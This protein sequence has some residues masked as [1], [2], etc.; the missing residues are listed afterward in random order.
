VVRMGWVAGGLCVGLLGSLPLQAAAAELAIVQAGPQGEVASLEEANEVRVVFSEP[1]VALGRIPQPV[2]APFLRIAPSLAGSFRWSGTNT[3]IFTPADHARLPYATRYEVTVD[4]TATS[5][6]GRQLPRLYAFSFTTPT[7]RL[8][9]A[10]W[11]RAG[12]RYDAPAVIVLRFNQPVTHAATSPHIH[13]QYAPHEWT[14]PELPDEARQ[15]LSTVDPGA[16]HDFEAKVEGARAAAGS[17]ETV[18]VGL[19]TSWDEKAFPPSKDMLVFTTAGVPPPEAWIRAAIGPAIKGVQGP[20]TPGKPQEAT[21]K[22]ERTLFIDGFRC[23]VACDPDDHNPIVLRARATVKAAR[24]AVRVTD[25]TDPAAEAVLKAGAL[26]RKVEEEEPAESEEDY[27]LSGEV[28]LQDLGYAIRPARTY[29]ARVERTLKSVDGQVLGYTW[30]GLVENWHQRAFTSFGSGHGVWESGGGPLLPFQARNLESVRQWLAP[31]KADVLMPQ[32]RALQAESFKLSPPGEGTLR[33]LAPAPDAL[34]SYG[35]DLKPFL[36]ERG[37]GLVWAA[38]QDQDRMPKAK[39]SESPALKST[40]VQVTNLGISVK[41]SP[42]NVLVFVT[43]LDDGMPVEGATVSIRTLENT[44]YWTGVTDAR[45]T[46]VAPGSDLRDAE[47]HWELRFIVVA[48]KDGDVAYVASDWNEGVEPWE[49]SLTYDL[50]EARPLLRGAVF[51]DRG[52]YKLGEEVH[53]KTLLRSDTARGIVLLP[54]ATAVEVALQDSQG[55]EIDK[56]QVTLGEWSSADWTLRIPENGPLGRYG[57]TATVAGHREPVRGGFL[58]AAYRR[59]DFRVDANL[60]GETSLAGV[61]LKGEVT[62]RYLFGASMAS[63]PVRWTYSKAPL[64]DVPTAVTDRF[65]GERYAFLNEDWDPGRRRDTETMQT[66]EAELD[67]QGQLVLD[68]DTDLRSGLPYR[69]TLEGEVT[70]A[71]RQTIAGRASFRVDP[72]PWYI[73]LRRPPYFAD[74]KAG[75]DTEV[76]TADVSGQPVAGVPVHV[77]LMQVQWHSVRRAEGQGF[78]TWE[79]E[80]KEVEAGAWDVTTGPAPAPLH[81]P[82]ESGGSFILKATASD[83]EGRSTTTTTS[84]YV[85]GPGYT[86]W[87]RYDHN[88][89][90]LVP[91]KKAYRPGDVARILV[92]SPWE[93]ATAL[94]TTEREGVRTYKTFA[95]SSTQETVSVLVTEEDIPNVYV[96]VLLVKG[97]TGSYSAADT[98]DPG[99]PAFRLG[100]VELRVEEASRRLDVKLSTDREEYRPAAKAHVDV[101]IKD[102]AGRGGPAEVTLWA[103]DYGVLSLTAYK[104][105]DVLGSVYVAKALQV[106]NEDSRQNIISRRVLVPKGADEG[107]GGG[108]EEGPGTPVRKDFRVLAFWL[109]SLVTDARGKASADV[110]LPESLT[111]YRIMA[112]AGD[113]SSRFGWG[114]R[115]IRTSKPVLLKAAFPRFLALGDAARFGSVVHSQLKEK[116]TA[117]VTMKSLDPEVLEVTGEPRRTA[118]VAAKGAAELRFD[119]KARAVGRARVRMTVKLL[120]ESDAFEEVLPVEVLA[121]PEVVAAYGVANPEAHEAVDLPAGVVPGFGGLHVETAST[122]LVGLGE[123]ARYLVDYPYGCAEQ[124]ASAALALLL[125]ADLGEAFRLPGIEPAHLKETVGATLE[126]LEAYQC[127][128]GGFAFWKGGC[129]SASPYLTSYV[130]HVYQRGQKAGYRV[131][132]PVLDRGYAYLEKALAEGAP[133]DDG[134]WPAYTA[135]QAFA[136]KVLSEAGRNEDSHLTRL[137]D[138]LDRMPVFALSHLL[139]A[140]SARGEKGSRPDELRRRIHN[141]IL[142]EGGSAHV[143]ELSDPYLLWFWSSN[144]RSTAMVLGSLVRDPADDPLVP[145]I[146]RWLMKVRKD[147]RWGNT[148]ENAHAM[149]ALVD[150]YKRYE[151]EVPDFTGTVTLG[152]DVLARPEFRGRSTAV[153]TKDLPMRDLLARG[154]AGERLDLGFRKEG[155]GALHYVARLK[156][157]SNEPVAQGADQGF[158]IERTYVPAK[159]PEGAAP[160]Q[161]YQTGDLVTVTLKLRL[162]KERRYVAVTDPLPA[163]FEA[164]ES[165]FATTASDLAREQDAEESQDDDWRAWWQRGGFDHVERHDDRVLLF[166]TRLAEG[167]H[168][169]SYAV[170]ATTAGVFRTAPAHAEE[171]YEPEVFGRTATDVIEVRP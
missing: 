132:A 66:K 40:L 62:G 129:H 156:Y 21:I 76:V 119:V 26:P 45:G 141:A 55:Q 145:G 72:A 150:Y 56:R 96:S 163:G 11:Y 127:P 109:G 170:R 148:Q 171:M 169:F 6:A 68:L 136:V 130:L 47:R 5:L 135:W 111:T 155:A 20:E 30:V 80:R 74:I 51:S 43:R 112:V 9:Q 37:T 89:I 133:K 15:R 124:R 44:V 146:V 36:S 92:K 79:T 149:E 158:L 118:V 122:A 67:A 95:L 166:A 86:A 2:Q 23:R 125:A 38:L 131:K 162:T 3:L 32:I 114:E 88:R 59:P 126:E 19:A 10:S 123:G 57:V 90:D 16:A 99:K 137:Y 64:E 165:W 153:Q 93:K 18:K 28:T 63:R 82:L 35:L 46:A 115:E 52:V 70:D 71:S 120:G 147:G 108:A 50:H 1:M 53:F 75:L 161:T 81:V 12:G 144:V 60:A 151:Q 104:T 107:G 73:G 103:V 58:V 4:T 121:S 139:D 17:R 14:A 77:T 29:A 105:P 33:K 168:V 106:M 41:D 102:H 85:L 101:E 91:E 164:V 84:F 42:Q 94:L 87:Q 159:A 65:P 167:E 24:R 143:E 100:Y 128:E 110:L 157:A 160:L 34:Q 83:A 31:M 138:R 7:V 8:L 98:G 39:A 48:E 117:I 13:F 54:P 113:R 142:P 78:Y 97:R 116:G 152:M 134:W 49:F 69:Y 140:L 154:S 61:K 27:D 25:V 22:L